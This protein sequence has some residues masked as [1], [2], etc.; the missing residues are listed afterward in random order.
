MQSV[1]VSRH[2]SKLPR[3]VLFAGMLLAVAGY[4]AAFTVP[5][6]LAIDVGL[7]FVAAGVLRKVRVPWVFAAAAGLAVAAGGVWYTLAVYPG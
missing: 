4:L 5:G 1:A 7:G 6:A 3:V 2:P